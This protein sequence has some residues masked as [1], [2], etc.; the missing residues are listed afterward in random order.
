MIR[1]L[2]AILALM[3]LVAIV[4]GC[5]GTSGGGGSPSSS[6]KDIIEIPKIYRA[7]AI[8]TQCWPLH[9]PQ[10]WVY[11]YT[12]SRL[13][14]RAG[15]PDSVASSFSGQDSMRVVN[16]IEDVGHAT[17]FIEDSYKRAGE[18]FAATWVYAFQDSSVV[19]PDGAGGQTV[20]FHFPIAEGMRW[21]HDPNQPAQGD[22]GTWVVVG[23]DVASTPAGNFRS[24][25]LAYDAPAFTLY[26]WF[27]PGLGIVAEEQAPHRGGR[28]YRME[29]VR[30]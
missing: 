18:G 17:V 25:K 2:L 7:L 16:Y 12:Q 14:A 24:W 27:V 13:V 6:A 30:H 10:T 4:S 3:L 26:R 19:L 22:I 5:G 1:R 21:G 23:Q 29:L 28:A 9:A 8:P 11:N 20:I 15:R